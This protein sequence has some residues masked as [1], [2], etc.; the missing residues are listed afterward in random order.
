[1]GEEQEGM[2]VVR[3]QGSVECKEEEEEAMATG[4]FREKQ[5]RKI[6]Q[7]LCLELC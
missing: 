6:T 5:N 2:G 3:R 1:M 7:T 4:I